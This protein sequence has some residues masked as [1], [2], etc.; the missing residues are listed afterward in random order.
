[1]VFSPDENRSMDLEWESSLEEV[2]DLLGDR[3]HLLR[4]RGGVRYFRNDLRANHVPLARQRLLQK[5]RREH[6]SDLALFR[7]LRL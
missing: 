6:V 3:L 5:E 4:V 1:M 2:A 7:V